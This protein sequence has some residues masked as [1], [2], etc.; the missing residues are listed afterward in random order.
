[1]IEQQMEPPFWSARYPGIVLEVWLR[2][3]LYRVVFPKPDAVPNMSA[4]DTH[5]GDSRGVV[6]ALRAAQRYRDEHVD[7]FAECFA[8]RG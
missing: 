5:G 7:Q 4:F 1:M 2:G 8:G 3:V 6:E